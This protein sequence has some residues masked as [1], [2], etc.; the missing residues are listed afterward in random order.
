MWCVP[1]SASRFIDLHDSI[2]YTFK[3]IKGNNIIK[4]TDTSAVV[5]HTCHPRIWEAEAEGL[6]IQGHLQLHRD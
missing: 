3:E 5:A 6:R 2:N 1:V 4:H